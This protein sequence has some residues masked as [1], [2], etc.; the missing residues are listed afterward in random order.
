MNEQLMHESGMLSCLQLVLLQVGQ[1][2]ITE[3]VW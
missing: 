2:N 3:T 1:L